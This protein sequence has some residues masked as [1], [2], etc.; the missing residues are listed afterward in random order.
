MKIRR[1]ATLKTAE[2]FKNY[3]A[4]I[5]ADLPF[6]EEVESGPESPLAQP[7][8]YSDAITIGN[9]FMVH[10][11][12]GWDSELDGSPSELTIRRWER[13]GQSGAKFI[14][15]GEATAVRRYGRANPGQLMISA[16]NLG[17]FDDLR[18]RLIDTHKEKHGATDDLFA[19]L[20]LTHSGRFSRPND[21]SII[22]P[23]MLYRHPVLARK[24]N[25]APDVEPMSDD[26]LDEL[27]GDFAAAAKL[28]QEAGFQFV[29]IKHCHGYLGHE[30]LSA[31]SRPGKYGGNNC[32]P[33]LLC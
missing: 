14:W 10:P 19:G 29:D 2:D 3:A 27:V 20:Q 13:F 32:L 15:G 26:E 7:L 1:I 30:F 33:R 21:K 23:K 6:D 22:E 18:Q 4:E 28:A 8:R 9:R 24:F 17:A 31:F 5:G 25:V 16:E 11:M 12:E